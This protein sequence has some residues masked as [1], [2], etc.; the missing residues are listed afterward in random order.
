MR[1]QVPSLAPDMRKL[2]SLIIVMIIREWHSNYR[3]Q[4]EID[5]YIVCVQSIFMLKLKT[6]RH[7]KA[8]KEFLNLVGERSPTIKMTDV[9]ILEIKKLILRLSSQLFMK[10]TSW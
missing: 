5:C 2:L 9:A 8:D 3:K 7:L 6:I 10:F 4:L 1:V